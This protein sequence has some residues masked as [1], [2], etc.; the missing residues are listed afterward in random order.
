M[1]IFKKIMERG[2]VT[3][4]SDT[5]EIRNNKFCGKQFFYPDLKYV[6]LILP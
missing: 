6:K 3:K 4:R 5:N 1:L 2:D